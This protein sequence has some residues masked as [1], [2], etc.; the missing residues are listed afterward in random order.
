MKKT[1]RR[2]ETF[3]FYD[4]TGLESH[5]T[6]MAEKGWLLEKI[7]QFFWTYRK[8]E[9]KTLTFS[10][11]YFPEAS[12]FDP[13]PSEEQEAFYDLC[14]HSSWQLAA[15]SAQ[16]QVFY[17]EGPDPVPIDTDPVLEVESIHRTMKKS[18]IPSHLAMLALAVFQVV[19]F[20]WRAA[21]APIEN[22]ANPAVPL[23][24]LCWALVVALAGVELPLGIVRLAV[25]FMLKVCSGHGPK[26]EETCAT[27]QVEFLVPVSYWFQL[28]S[29]LGPML[30]P[31]HLCSYDSGH[32]PGAYGGE[33]LEPGAFDLPRRPA[34]LLLQASHFHC[35]VHHG[36]GGPVYAGNHEVLQQKGHWQ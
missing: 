27:G 19:M 14:A 15:A 11:T 6:R 23:I 20:V 31:T 4:R 33:E 21:E 35:A 32:D 29:V 17:N 34:G 12:Q 26:L 22:L 24:A 10:V 2:L 9:P 13:G 30:C 16:L 28:L 18:L 36:A 3:S 7:G 5:L 25:E 8:I 1:K